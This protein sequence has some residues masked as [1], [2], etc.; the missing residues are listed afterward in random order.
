[1]SELAVDS[2]TGSS[3][4][5]ASP[6]T[7]S[8][9]TATLGSGAD[10]KGA[11]NASGTAPIYACRAFAN[12]DAI[13][14]SS[15]D[16]LSFGNTDAINHIGAMFIKIDDKEMRQELFKMLQE[17]SKFVLE[18]SQKVVMNRRLEIKQVK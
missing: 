3:A 10:I 14:T 5:G 17:H 2:I 12:F 8:G 6:I 13:D 4:V 11:I 7:L 15:A 1:M 18:T 16:P 9:N